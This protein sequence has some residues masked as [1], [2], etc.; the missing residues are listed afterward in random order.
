MVGEV[1]SSPLIT[2]S[3]DT[4]VEEAAEKMRDNKIRRLLVKNELGVVGIVSESD[5]V[6]VEPELHLLIREKA[7]LEV[8]QTGSV[9]NRKSSFTRAQ[10]I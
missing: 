9:V 6:R 10:F 2:I 4:S 7:R 1:L 5:I 3:E 8:Y